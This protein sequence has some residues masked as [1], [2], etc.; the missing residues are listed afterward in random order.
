MIAAAGFHLLDSGRRSDL[1]DD[2]YSRAKTPMGQKH[3]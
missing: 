3:R 2:V 1:P